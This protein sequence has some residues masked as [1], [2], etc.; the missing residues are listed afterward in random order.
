[1]R[2]CCGKRRK[3][4]N[5]LCEI[6]ST[7]WLEMAHDVIESTVIDDTD[8]GRNS[9]RSPDHPWDRADWAT[10][11]GNHILACHILYYAKLYSYKR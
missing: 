1:M 8:P 9:G 2:Y 5:A 4:V 11:S 3:A 7:R 6:L 10:N